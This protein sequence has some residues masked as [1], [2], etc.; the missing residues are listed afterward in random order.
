MGRV[1][2]RNLLKIKLLQHGFTQK[3]ISKAL[4][5]TEAYVSMLISGKRKSEAFTRWTQKNLKDDFNAR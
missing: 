4:N 5:V 1:S 3:D 2:N